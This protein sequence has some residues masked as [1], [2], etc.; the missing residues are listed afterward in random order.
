MSPDRE[1]RPDTAETL[2]DPAV[3]VII[4]CWILVEEFKGAL[5]ALMDL[6][7][8]PPFEVIVVL[9]GATAESSAIATS[10]PVVSRV[11]SL[12]ANVGF[13][14]A[15]NIAASMARG[16]SLV[17]LND[18]TRVDAHWL[19]ALIEAKNGENHPSVVASLLL[20]FD[21]TVQEAGSRI[22]SHGG[23]MQW[24]RGLAWQDAQA[25]GLLEPR[26][27]DYGS[28]AALLVRRAVFEAV[29]G[30]DPVFE[31]A[32]FEDVDLQ[33]RIRELGESIWFEPRARVAHHLGK[34]TSRDHWF[35]AFAANR[36]GG[37][38][39]AKWSHVLAGAPSDDD[40]V[41][42]LCLVEPVERPPVEVV[43]FD[44]DNSPLV[45][46]AIADEYQTW[47]VEQLE[48]AR[49]G[50]PGPFAA[51]GGPTRRE[52]LEETARLRDRIRNLESR[53]PVGVLRM[54]A[55]LFLGNRGLLKPP[56]K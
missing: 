3:S 49:D 50:Q 12:Q 41:N 54:R 48:E 45:A 36:S 10:H 25:V 29:G 34:S 32:Y 15:A 35:R 28:A 16:E 55:G 46:L 17:F 30:F 38:F 56:R 42:A 8:V 1:R 6:V 24:G 31:P 18:D 27:I 51:A 13:G 14:A 40:P 22:L 44:V 39:V 19:S 53:G 21:G 43:A 4:V 7:D 11:V 37:R 5:D 23:T 33:L 47:L 2:T 20:D 52:L 26:E 9:N